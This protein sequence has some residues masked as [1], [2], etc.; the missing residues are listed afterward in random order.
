MNKLSWTS[1]SRV[2]RSFSTSRSRRLAKK[3]NSIEFQTRIKQV[4][5]TA[6]KQTESYNQFKVQY[7]KMYEDFK[8][9]VE[10]NAQLTVQKDE[11]ETKNKEL[12]REMS[13]MEDQLT[14]QKQKIHSLKKSESELSML[15]SSMK[16][17]NSL[18]LNNDLIHKNQQ[19]LDANTNF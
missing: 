3:D 5:Q 11:Y 4:Q 14:V 8:M 18:V 13:K 16:S 2:Y 15:R 1:C 9:I 10:Q 19:L 17:L 12:T 7:K 6:N